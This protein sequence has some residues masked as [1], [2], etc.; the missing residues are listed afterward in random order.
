MNWQNFA[1][2]FVTAITV[3]SLQAQT[4]DASPS[5]SPGGMHHG[6]GHH[7]WIWRK[8]NLT[9]AQKKQI[10][11]IWQNNRKNPKFRSDLLA[12]LRAKQT[13]QADAKANKTDPTHATALGA[14]EAKLAVA[15]A[16]LRAQ[17]QNEIKAVLTPEQQQTWSDFQ[18]KRE[19]FLQKRIEKLTSQSDS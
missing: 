7:A 5:P 17:E 11:S 14:A 15:R 6:M 12:Y 10:H 9:D 3:A 4:P 13:V 2:P 19:S 8:L 1:L 18:A 16:Q